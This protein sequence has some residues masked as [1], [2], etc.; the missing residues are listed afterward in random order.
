MPPA[1]EHPAATDEAPNPGARPLRARLASRAE[2]MMGPATRSW[3]IDE[4]LA[5]EGLLELH[6]R[7][8]HDAMEVLDREHGLSVSMLGILGRLARAEHRTLSQTALAEAINLSLSRISR[9]VDIL[10]GRGLV[11]RH[12]CPSDGRTTNILLADGGLAAAEA[13]QDT[14]RAFVQERF[15]ARLTEEEAA[16]LARVFLGLLEDPAES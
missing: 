6:R 15:L 7:L 10:E 14:V 4:V 8:F 13:A 9:I 3:P 11:Q 5:W 2:Y 1:D 16:A 12:P